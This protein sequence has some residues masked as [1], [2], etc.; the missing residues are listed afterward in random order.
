MKVIVAMTPS[1]IIGLDGAMPWHYPADMKRFK[2]LTM[3]GVVV[4]GR[5][6]WLTLPKGLPGRRCIVVS[7][8]FPLADSAPDC[9]VFPNLDHALQSAHDGPPRQVWV[10][11]G[12][13][14]YRAVL[15]GFAGGVGAVDLTLL[16]EIEPPAADAVV[17]R[18]PTDLLESRFTLDSEERNGEDPRLLHRTYIPKH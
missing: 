10:C 4:M 7:R 9:D 12:E 2:R 1:G 11:G 18:F 13:A 6:T 16:P 3:G 15:E 17:A 5:K 8:D 14:I